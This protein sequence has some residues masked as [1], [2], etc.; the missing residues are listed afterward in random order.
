MVLLCLLF[1]LNVALACHPESRWA[2]DDP[3]DGAWTCDDP[4]CPLLCEA[5]CDYS[6]ICFNE[7]TNNSYAKSCEVYCP[8]DQCQNEHCPACEI[9]CPAPCVQGYTALCDQP[10]C[11]WKCI[12]DVNCPRP[13]CQQTSEWQP[14]RHPTCELASEM[15]ACMYSSS[16]RLSLF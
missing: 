6:C 15:P 2:C 5:I 1:L 13:V 4:V 14:C 9:R 7:L 16:K 12:P 11:A 10:R 3:C 8:P